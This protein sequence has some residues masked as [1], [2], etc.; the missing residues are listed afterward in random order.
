MSEGA[1]RLSRMAHF[2]APSYIFSPVGL[3]GYRKNV[4][5]PTAGQGIV[6]SAFDVIPLRPSLRCLK[7]G[8]YTTG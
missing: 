2:F 4:A 1:I 6:F 3:E 8:V 7:E 5:L